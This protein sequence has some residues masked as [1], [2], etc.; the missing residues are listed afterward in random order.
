MFYLVK[1]LREDRVII[2]IFYRH[3]DVVENSV[4][5]EFGNGFVEGINNGLNR[6]LSILKNVYRVEKTLKHYKRRLR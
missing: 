1:A 4:E 6:F 5:Y 3:I 2:E